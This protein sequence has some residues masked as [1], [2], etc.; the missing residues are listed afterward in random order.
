MLKANNPTP[1]YST[2]GKVN[3]HYVKP[4]HD[5]EPIDEDI[6]QFSSDDLDSPSPNFSIGR[7]QDAKNMR[8]LDS[9]PSPTKAVQASFEAVQASFVSKIPQIH[10][11]SVVSTKSPIVVIKKAAVPTVE[12]K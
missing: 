12:T 4:G 7:T 6:E 11:Q 2:P 3:P 9:S 5:D 1:K 8:N 10:S